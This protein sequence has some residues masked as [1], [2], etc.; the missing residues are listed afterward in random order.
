MPSVSLEKNSPVGPST[1]TRDRFLV[2]QFPI[3]REVVMKELIIIF[4]L[5]ALGFI[6][7][8]ATS[9]QAGIRMNWKAISADTPTTTELHHPQSLKVA[10]SPPPDDRGT[11]GQ[12]V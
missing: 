6:G 10:D 1:Q 12:R 9:W 7:S 3:D 8:L 5:V 11:P 2:D 4:G